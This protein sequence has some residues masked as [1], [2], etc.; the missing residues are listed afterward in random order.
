VSPEHHSRKVGRDAG[1]TASLIAGTMVAAFMGAGLLSGS[2]SVTAL[3]AI[4]DL[5]VFAPLS[6][7]LLGV[8]NLLSFLVV[9]VRTLGAWSFQVSPT[10]GALLGA[11]V[12]T[13]FGAAVMV[14][15]GRWHAA[16]L[17]SNLQISTAVIQGATDANA[18]ES[19]SDVARKMLADRG[20][21]AGPDH[22]PRPVRHDSDFAAAEAAAAQLLLQLQT[23]QHH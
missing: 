6:K 5:W 1:G 13:V 22:A 12:P 4:P 7:L 21:Q 17:R 16:V 10:A 19:A 23:P 3:P 15:S 18:P 20:I 14:R 8:A 9:D 11:L 2:W